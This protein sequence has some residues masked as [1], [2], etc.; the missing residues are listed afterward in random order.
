MCLKFILFLLCMKI[1]VVFCE[2][3]CSD[4]ETCGSCIGYAF[5]R[6]VWCSAEEHEGSRC[7]SRIQADE[8]KHWCKGTPIYDP[9]SEKNVTL[10]KDFNAGEKGEPVI[11]FRPQSLNIK[12][13]PGIPVKISM[14]YKP[15]K[16]YPLDVYYLMDYSHTMTKHAETLK[17][18]GFNIYNELI[19]LTNNVR[20][21]VGSFVEKNSLPYVDDTQQN[22]YSFKN[23]LSLTDNMNEFAEA[24]KEKPNGSNYDDPEASLDGLMQAMVCKKEV[25]WRD[26]ARRIIVLSTDSTYH[27]AGDGKFV[28]AASPH[29]MKCYV[30]NNTYQMELELDYP[31]VS[32]INKVAA[33]N[34]IMIIFSADKKVEPHYKALEKKV[35]GSKY[36]PLKADSTLVNVIKTEYLSL[37]RKVYLDFKIPSFMQLILDQDCS[38]DNE[39]ELKH[40]QSVEL[41]GT[42]TITSCPPKNDYKYNVEIGPRMLNEKLK[43]EV[44]IYCQCDCEKPGRGIDNSDMCNNAGTYQCGIC[45]CDSDRYGSTCQCNGISTDDEDQCKKNNQTLPCSGRGTCSCGKCDPCLSGFSGPY[46][47]YDD[48]ACPSPEGLLCADHGICKYGQCQCSPNWIGEDCRCPIN[49]ESCKAPYS[50]EVCSGNGECSCGKCECKVCSGQFCDDCEE[51]AM[52][53][54]KELEDFAYCNF[55]ENKKDCDLKFNQTNTEVTLVNKTEINSPDWYMAKY[56]CRKVLEDE[57]I[58]VFKYYYSTSSNS[59]LHLIIQNELEKPPIANVWIAVGSVI[60]AVLLIGLITLIAWK[61]LVDLHDKREYDKFANE[62]AAAGFD[63]SI[64]P[65]Y[66]SP[67]TNFQNPAYDG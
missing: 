45:N 55:N 42:L 20:L 56:W 1:C 35:L 67:A 65:L 31:S 24:L 8:S 19:K 30:V 10:N 2:T 66:Q 54:C 7:K 59:K 58:F 39:C 29:D 51:V 14:S 46:C 44:D 41:T 13:R 64:N 47:E 4:F 52:K 27:S 34:N 50:K 11:Q 3:G 22:S 16:D 17:N 61:I 57:Q 5:D 23:H 28:G 9:E 21:G 15:A 53:R 25:G 40:N 37:I 38:R 18:Q 33:E 32:Q 6:C 36:V 12:A 63:T 62:S 60:G 26:N 49:N 43:I 48:T